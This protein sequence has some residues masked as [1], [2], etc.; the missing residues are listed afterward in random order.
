[1]IAIA[2]GCASTAT[3]MRESTS[4]NLT[5]VPADKARIVFLRSSFVGSAISAV[6]SEVAD[7]EPKFVGVL[8]NG[9]KIAYDVPAGKRL[10]MVTSESADFLEANL[11]AGKTYYAFVTPRMGVW[12][13]RFSFVA[14]K[15]TADGLFKLGSEEFN[16]TLANNKLEEKTP[17]GEKWFS[18]NIRDIKEKQNEYWV[19]WNS[20]E[21][22]SPERAN[23]TLN[24]GDSL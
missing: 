1:M 14:A 15:T 10:F 21:K 23:Q 7:S 2:T 9:R 18:E 20:T 22:S 13:A 24:I 19:K 8:Q 3:Y 11:A 6:V 4:Q 17:E 5:T 12:K 16:K